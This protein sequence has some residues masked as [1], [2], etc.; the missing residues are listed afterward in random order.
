MSGPGAQASRDGRKGMPDAL[1]SKSALGPCVCP[2]QD[3]ARYRGLD[4]G[5]WDQGWKCSDGVLGH[6]EGVQEGPGH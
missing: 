1:M 5:I 3:R 4:R 6:Q 2:G